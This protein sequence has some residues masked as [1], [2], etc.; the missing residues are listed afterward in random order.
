MHDSFGINPRQT[1]ANISVEF[2]PQIEIKF[3]KVINSSLNFD[4]RESNIS[5]IM[6]DVILIRKGKTRDGKHLHEVVQVSDI[7]T[8][9]VGKKGERKNTSDVVVDELG[10]VRPKRLAWLESLYGLVR[11]GHTK[12]R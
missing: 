2:T 10:I 11:S 7:P 6:A 12:E 4:Q 3:W 8:E 5:F 9:V 1:N